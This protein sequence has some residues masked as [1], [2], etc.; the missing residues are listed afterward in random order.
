MFYRGSSEPQDESAKVLG[1]PE[2]ER[3]KLKGPWVS[4][5]ARTLDVGDTWVSHGLWGRQVPRDLR[6]DA[7]QEYSLLP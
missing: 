5:R 6:D 3:Q 4:V 2:A 1:D 7:G